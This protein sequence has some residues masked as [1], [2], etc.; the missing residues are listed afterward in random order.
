MKNVVYD[1]VCNL[2]VILCTIA[3]TCNIALLYSVWHPGSG[4][5]IFGVVFKR[6]TAI[7]FKG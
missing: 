3:F 1:F 4:S 6:K 2:L 7:D 5:S